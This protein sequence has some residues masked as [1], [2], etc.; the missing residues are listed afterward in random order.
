MFMEKK[1]LMH[2]LSQGAPDV[3]DQ[4]GYL[5]QTHQAHPQASK[6]DLR[7]GGE[8]ESKV[9]CLMFSDITLGHWC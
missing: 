8:E 7:V 6:A 3:T 1:L 2:W 9:F 5:P 4:R